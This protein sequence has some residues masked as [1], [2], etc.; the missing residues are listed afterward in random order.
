MVDMIEG[1]G[2][3]TEGG[4]FARAL[5]PH[6][7]A[8]E[9]S[10]HDPDN[11]QNCGTALVGAYCH[12]CGQ[13]GHLHRTIGAFVHDLLHGAL[14]FE[15]KLWR[16][17]PML[18]FRPGR[19]TRRYIDGERA[20]F[21]SPMALFLFGVFLMF[22]VFQMVGITAPSTLPSDGVVSELSADAENMD[23]E[24]DVAVLGSGEGLARARRERDAMQARIDALPADD[25]ARADMERELA[26][27]EG[28]IAI[29]EIPGQVARQEQAARN[30][31][32]AAGDALDEAET[33]AGSPATG[34]GTGLAFIDRLLHKWQEN[35]GLM[36][37][38]LQSNAYKFSWLLIPI[39][40]P[41]VWLLFAWRRR[42][43]AYDHA[44]FVTY[45]LSFMTLMFIALSLARAMGASLNVIGIAAM[46]IAPIHLYKQLRGTY[47]LSRFSAA[48]RLL[49]MSAF[50]WVILA[51]FVQ[52]LVVLGAF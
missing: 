44:I 30:E 39:S 49:M 26:V 47:T 12:S 29:L 4:L 51:L 43:K 37:Y 28:S 1:I 34:S 36:I 27:L 42:F 11:C 17:L 48:W 9:R 38:K 18:A 40:I 50:I 33:S 14:H 45:S 7:G 20:R 46:V 8:L 10:E 52:I 13:R 3:A 2:T 23:A 15:G 22:A 41:F 32:A 21:V 35:P 31:S 25:P 24:G 16:T 19:L 5:E 6:S